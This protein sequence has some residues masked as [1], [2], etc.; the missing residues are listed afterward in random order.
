MKPHF[1]ARL[2][3]VIALLFAIRTEGATDFKSQVSPVLKQYCYKCH[4][5]QSKPKAKGD[6]KLDDLANMTSKIG[7]ATIKP[8]NAAQSTLYSTFKLPSS[9]DDHMPPKKEP[10]PTA[11]QMNVIMAW[12]NEGASLEGKAAAAPGA[13]T[14]PP[15]PG[16]PPATGAPMAPAAAG[17][18]KAWTSA[19]GKSIQASFLRLE[20]ENVVIQREDGEAFIVPLSK[21]SP[22]S[23]ALAKSGGK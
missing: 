15:A 21:L 5:T 9:D 3:L 7:T 20:G 13:P 19:D 18:M 22:E 10:Q 4:S 17:E 11:A 23:Q 8:G 6:L 2:F 16:T 12:I 14:T 1:T